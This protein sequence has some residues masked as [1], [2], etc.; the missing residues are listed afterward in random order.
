MKKSRKRSMMSPTAISASLRSITRPRPGNQWSAK[1]LPYAPATASAQSTM[2]TSSSAIA[3]ATHRAPVTSSQK[4]TFTKCSPSARPCSAL[5][6][7][8]ERPT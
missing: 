6:T 5:T 8:A 4:R 7:H 3:P 1:A 2:R